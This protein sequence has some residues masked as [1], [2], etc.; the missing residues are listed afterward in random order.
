MNAKHIRWILLPALLA[1]ALGSHADSSRYL[2]LLVIPTDAAKEHLAPIDAFSQAHAPAMNA[3]K[4]LEKA[5]CRTL[6]QLPVL[7]AP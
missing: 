3:W 4:T 7:E 2:R 6:V 1:A 5:M